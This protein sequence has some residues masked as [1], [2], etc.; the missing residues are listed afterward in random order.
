MNYETSKNEPETLSA[1]DLKVGEMCRTLERIEAP[2]DF[3]FKLTARIANAKASDFAPRRRFI[4]AL[5]YALPALA[6]ILVLGLLAYNGGFFPAG[7][8]SAVAVSPVAPQTVDLP[9]NRAVSNFT[10][11]S[12]TANANAA[13]LPLNQDSPKPKEIAVSQQ[14][15]SETEAT[16][17]RPENVGGGSTLQSLT[18]SRTIMPRFNIPPS[19]P[20]NSQTDENPNPITVSEVLS[21][22]GINANFDNGKWSVKSVTPNSLGDSSGVRQND[23]I[24]EID[25][26]TVSG[27]TAFNKIVNG[28]TVTVTRGGQKIVIQLRNKQ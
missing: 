26:Q 12:E 16:R 18:N 8:N 15:K 7:N 19:V 20:Q 28:K 24:E 21:Q 22:M 1:D 10:P 13:V 9:Q 3:D 4:P 27:T 2:K 17:R 11:S 5:S 6:L 23:V 25:N 14:K